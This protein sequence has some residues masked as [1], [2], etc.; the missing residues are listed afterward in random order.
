MFSVKPG[1]TFCVIKIELS[2]SKMQ[3][4]ASRECNSLTQVSSDT[5]TYEVWLLNNEIGFKNVLIFVSAC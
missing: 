2:L 3:V 4:R 5:Y 1:D